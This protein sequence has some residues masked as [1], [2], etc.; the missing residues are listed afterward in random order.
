MNHVTIDENN[1][2]AYAS[3]NTIKADYIDLNYDKNSYCENNMNFVYMPDEPETTYPI[4]EETKIE[5]KDNEEKDES[6]NEDETDDIDD[7]EKKV[8]YEISQTYEC[9]SFIDRFKELGQNKVLWNKIMVEIKEN[10]V[11]MDDE[12][13]IFN[14]FHHYFT[15]LRKLPE[16]TT[17]E[18]I[19]EIPETTKEEKETVKNNVNESTNDENDTKTNKK[20]R[21]KDQTGKHENLENT[22]ETPELNKC[23]QERKRN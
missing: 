14:W 18:E 4:Q 10:K 3:C 23:Q 16:I 1:E 6:E 20:E 8:L 5:D 15:G 11:N 13:E 12:R 7:D 22:R 17:E 21:F 19:P 9:K 2:T